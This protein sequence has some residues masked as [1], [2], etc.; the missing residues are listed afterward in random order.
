MKANFVFFLLIVLISG[1]YSLGQTQ[2]EDVSDDSPKARYDVH[3]EYDENG[4]LI[5]YDSVYISSWDSDTA[6]AEVDSLLD[7]WEYGTPN[8]S[9]PFHYGFHFPGDPFGYLPELEFDFVI[10]DWHN[11]QEGFEYNYSITPT[12]SVDSPLFPDDPVFQYRHVVP[13]E[14]WD[15]DIEEQIYEM[16]RFME[17]FNRRE[18][19]E[20]Y[21]PDYDYSNP[22]SFPDDST[23]LPGTGPKLYENSFD[24]NIII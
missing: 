19:W 15:L 3:R 9:H 2:N 21:N 8:H 11:L 24:G 6:L 5:Y 13:P 10:P 23:E 7:V 4:N 20:F 17:E 16:E 1:N 22:D 14:G 18:E 12:D